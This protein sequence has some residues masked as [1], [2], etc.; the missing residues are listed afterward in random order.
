MGEVSM[1][2]D[3]ERALLLEIN[4]TRE[5]AEDVDVVPAHL[6]VNRDVAITHSAYCR[7]ALSMK[8]R[9]IC[10]VHA[11]DVIVEDFGPIAEAGEVIE[12]NT[13]RQFF[14][15]LQNMETASLIVRTRRDLER[16]EK[17]FVT[18]QR[19][20]AGDDGAS[21]VMSVMASEYEEQRNALLRSLRSAEQTVKELGLDEDG[22]MRFLLL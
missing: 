4:N 15:F 10:G 8:P 19:A 12:L 13:M 18:G 6:Y 16:L 1:S 11:I 22:T 3:V 5:D 2:A 21:N 7:G 9:M 14:A 17:D 20:L